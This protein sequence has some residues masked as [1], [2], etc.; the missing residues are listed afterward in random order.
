MLQDL[1]DAEQM[2]LAQCRHAVLGDGR[3]LRLDCGVDLG[4]YRV[5]YQTYGTLNADKTNAV[6]VCHPLSCDQFVA[7]RHPV[8]GKEGWWDSLVGPGKVLDPARYFII[9]VNVLGH[10]M[11][12]TGPL[13]R[14]ASTGQPWNLRFPVVTI[15]DMVRAQAALLDH[16]G[17]P[18]LF[19]V[20]GGS[21]GGMQVLEWAAT[22]P[23]RV[24]SAVP[25][26][27]AAHHSAQNIAFHEVGRQAIMADPEWKGGDYR[28]HQTVPARGLAVA[29]MTAH[30]TYLSEQALQRKFGRA[31]QDRNALGFGFD[32]DFQVESYLRHQG[33][34]FVDRFDA[35]SYLYI[36]RAM[37]YFDLAGA[38]GGVLANAFRKS[39][40][41]FCLMSFTSDWLFPTR[42]SR[43]IVHALNAAAANVSFV[44]VARDT[45]H[46]AFLLDEPEM[47]RT[48]SG[49]L[50]GAAAVRGLK[51]L[52]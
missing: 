47:F 18:D 14:E 48:L 41:R 10:C 8:T 43:E 42:E 29:R 40:T 1:T 7:E 38:H 9:C 26:A 51:D 13:A 3:P 6:L 50:K 28:L 17:I 36:T 31:L 5:A 44:E 19:C 12:T 39:A 2:A 25:I 11:G 37:D 46:A 15:G 34:T 4:P 24:F 35:N 23:K 30:I 16:L 20:I 52:S 32:A 45:G 33:S 22:Y 49:F 27:C 21:M